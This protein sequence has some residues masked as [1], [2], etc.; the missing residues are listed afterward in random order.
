M[1]IKTVLCVLNT[2]QDDGELKT[3]ID[4]AKRAE[5]HLM[6]LVLGIAPPAPSSPYGVVSSDIW[7]RE[8]ETGRGDAQR[9]AEKIESQLAKAGV[10][11]TVSAQ[12]VEFSSISTISARHA[13]YAD[14]TLVWPASEQFESFQRAVMDGALFESGRSVLLLG[15]GGGNVTFPECRRAVIA[16]DASVEAS[17]AVRDAI[18]I[19]AG[20]ET[21]DAVLVDPEPSLGGHGQEPGADLAAYLSRHA[22]EVTIHRVPREGHGVADII[23]RFATDRDADLVVMGGYAHSRLRQRIFGGT[24]TDM[25]KNIRQPILMAH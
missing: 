18:P 1:S 13:R 16:W 3:A 23:N 24:T 20:A 19:L 6:V 8:N 14:I 4:L 2:S 7:V 25:M 11:A 12:F 22:V 9:R 10:S 21:V 5:A 15:N 17:K